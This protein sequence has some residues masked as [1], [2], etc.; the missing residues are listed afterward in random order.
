MKLPV[1]FIQLPLLFDAAALAA[2]VAAFDE[3]MWR[4]HPTGM[5]GN[6]ALPLVTVEGDP[7]RGDSLEG[8]M[9][10]TPALLASPYLMQ[11]L[12]S[13]RAVIGRVRLMRLSGRAEVNLHVDTDYY[14]NERVRVHVPILTQPTVRFTC[15]DAQVNMAAGECWIFDTWRLHHVLNDDDSPRIHLV[16]DSVGG[17]D[18]WDLVNAGRPHTAPRAGWAAGHVA[19]GCGA[20]PELMFESVNSQ[21]PMSLWELR[22]HMSFVFAEVEPQPR[23]EP[24]GRLASAFVSRWQTLWFRHGT[25]E[26]ALPEY[27]ALLDAFLRQV[28]P[29]ARGIA[30][31]NGADLSDAILGLLKR[32]VRR[33]NAPAS[34]EESSRS[35]PVRNAAA[36]KTAD[37]R[38]DFERPVFIVSPPRSGSTL[39][40]E[41][42]SRSPDA[43]TIGGESHGLIEG[44]PELDTAARGHV[45]N[46]LDEN[47][48][49]PA[50][51]A[52]L[53]ERFR[54]RVFDRQLRKP[55]PGPVR[56]LEK[57]P[58]NSLRIPFLHKVFPDAMFVY[59][60]RD[61]REVLAS[62]LEAW[63]SG[64]F[65]TYPQLRGWTGPP[66]SLLLTP[67]WQ[68]WAGRPLVD[69]VAAQWETTTRILLEDLAAL[70]PGRCV[71]ARYEALLD[72][73]GREIDRLCAAVGFGWDEAVGD[74]L[75]VA[76]HTVSAPQ[77]GKW[78]RRQAEITPLL[79]RISTTADRAA[80]FASR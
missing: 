32:A 39:L 38:D 46:R 5:P 8:P 12:G 76:R 13:L 55:G 47:D 44:M 43:Y 35:G 11:V 24:V 53:R 54:N 28:M 56:L 37:G 50:I 57:T 2:E 52:A 23:L 4:P 72:N 45:S 60:Y 14:W 15:G 51:A 79:Q 10:P 30:L 36:A 75:P 58:K 63:E 78:R 7:A 20:V 70:P 19:P 41:T 62:M 61:P 59:L 49:T 22:G 73:P 68:E 1:P 69:I 27:T 18:F 33:E 66:W 16:V 31:R 48:A 64:G 80:R 77:E 34:S 67:G 40:F 74:G 21:S 42:L 6:S 25:N 17:A 65:R 26:T 71:V 9:R 29:V 3:G